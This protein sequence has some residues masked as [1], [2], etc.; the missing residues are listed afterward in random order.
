[1]YSNS[2]RYLAWNILAETV[3]GWGIYKKLNPNSFNGNSNKKQC[4]QSCLQ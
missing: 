2:G 4:Y 1:M 3:N